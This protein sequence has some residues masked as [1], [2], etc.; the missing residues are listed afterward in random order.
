VHTLH[1]LICCLQAQTYQN[2]KVL[3][4]HD[5][6]YIRNDLVPIDMLLPWSSEAKVQFLQTPE[7]KGDSGH[8]WRIWGAQQTRGNYI[9]FANDDGWYAPVYLE[10]L[11]HELTVNGARFAFCDFVRSHK[12]WQPHCCF[13]MAGSIDIGNWI[14]EAELVKTTPWVNFGF[15]GD[16]IFVEEMLKR[17]PGDKVRKV[18]HTLFVHN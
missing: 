12:L 15:R 14:A 5:G 10:A 18:S 9:G 3:I 16:G 13:P 8:H 11:L 1:G 17:I 4:I 7:R 6:P 2:W